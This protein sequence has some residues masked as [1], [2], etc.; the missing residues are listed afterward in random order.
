MLLNKRAQ[1]LASTIRPERKCLLADKG[2]KSELYIYDVIGAA[3]GGVSARDV[4]AQLKSAKGNSLDIHILSEGG[5]VFEAKGIYNALTQFKG[6]KTVYV[7]GLA[8][9]AATFVM[10]AGDKIL[11]APNSTFM[12]HGVW[13]GHTGDSTS[14]RTMADQLELETKSIAGIY[15]KRTGK[16][17][18][19]M[20]NLL[21][22]ETWFDTKQAIEMKFVDGEYEQV[23][24]AAVTPLFNVTLTDIQVARLRSQLVRK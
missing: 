13:T 22:G 8:A 18:D 10:M 23:Q 21:S 19:E 20:M 3:F 15:S 16:T 5:D 24:S 7:D 9:S 6:P 11:A 4:I 14:M 12:V 17:E 1:E 2:G